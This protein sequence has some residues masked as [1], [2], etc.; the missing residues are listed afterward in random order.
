MK[1]CGE[2]LRKALEAM[3]LAISM[4]VLV[5]GAAALLAARKWQ[6]LGVSKSMNQ[7]SL[8]VN[9]LRVKLKSNRLDC[10]PTTLLTYSI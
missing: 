2:F 4:Q 10:T 3:S 5:K 7:S 8:V 1:L 9:W 6:A